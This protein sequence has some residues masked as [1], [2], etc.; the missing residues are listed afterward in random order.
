MEHTKSIDELCLFEDDTFIFVKNK[1]KF[2]SN[3]ATV[4]VNECKSLP[5]AVITITQKSM[6]N[7]QENKLKR[8]KSKKSL[9]SEVTEC[10]KKFL[11]SRSDEDDDDDTDGDSVVSLNYEHNQM[12]KCDFENG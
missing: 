6:N 11:K 10:K 7:C 4:N 3:P 12:L 2:L 1:V 5:S 8:L 9:E